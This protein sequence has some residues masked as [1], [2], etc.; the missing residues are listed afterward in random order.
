MANVPDS[1]HLHADLDQTFQFD[2]DPDSTFNLNADPVAAP[3]MRI[4]DHWSTDPTRLH[5]E[6]ST[7]LHFEL[8]KLLNF[9]CGS[10]SGFSLMMQIWIRNTACGFTDLLPEFLPSTVCV[11][12][13]RQ[14]CSHHKLRN[15]YFTDS[16]F[17]VIFNVPIRWLLPV[18]LRIRSHMDA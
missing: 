3:V 14:Q 12:L 15:T 7:A 1:H 13:C 2:V 9:L 18:W 8:A 5:C 17:L 6:R 11:S 16:L 10:G 4:Y